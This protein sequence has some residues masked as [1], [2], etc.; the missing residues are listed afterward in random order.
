MDDRK[1]QKSLDLKKVEAILLDKLSD[2]ELE[3]AKYRYGLF[4]EDMLD[5][6][7]IGK[8]LKLRGKKLIEMIQRI[9]EK[10]YNLLKGNGIDLVIEEETLDMESN[11]VN[12][13]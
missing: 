12:M 3:I 2:R 7:Q 8:V 10:T 1:V 6:K 11:Y 13:D 9:D 5:A 4:N